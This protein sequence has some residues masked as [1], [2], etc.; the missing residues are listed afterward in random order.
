MLSH[1]L[2]LLVQVCECGDAPQF[3]GAVT[4]SS[5]EALECGIVCCGWNWGEL[6]AG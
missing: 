4:T 5:G 1:P 2:A 3:E 6:V